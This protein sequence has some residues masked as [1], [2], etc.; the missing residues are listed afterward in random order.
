MHLPDVLLKQMLVAVALPA[1]AAH[2]LLS[3]VVLHVTEELL[4]SESAGRT[5][6]ALV[7]VT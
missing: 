4:G 3:H 2:M 6:A 1:L 7:Q 5:V